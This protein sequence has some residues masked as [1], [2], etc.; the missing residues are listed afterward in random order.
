MKLKKVTVEDIHTIQDLAE[1][2]W[3]S[4]Y[5]EILSI[6]QIRYMLKNMYNKEEI[7][8][9]IENLNW[10]YFLL[11]DNEDNFTGFIGYQINHKLNTTKLHRIYVLP[12]FLGKGFGKFAINFLKNNI[13]KHGNN[14]IILNVNKNNPAVYFYKSQGFKI[15]DSG[16]FDI[17]NGFVM[18]DYLM[19]FCF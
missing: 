4:T 12:K 16:V 15:Y 6:E 9:H 3:H 2:S 18:D 1:E 14:R 11:I 10:E 7:Y 5:S 19:D 17:G 8:S 13:Q